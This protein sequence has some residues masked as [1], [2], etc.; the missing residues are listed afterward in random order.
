MNAD[1][2]I[3]EIER[4]SIDAGDG[5]KEAGCHAIDDCSARGRARARYLVAHRTQN[6][7]C[8]CAHQKMSI[9]ARNRH[10][11]S[12]QLRWQRTDYVGNVKSN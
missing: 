2:E 1:Q 6:E 7:T 12:E 3:R 5:E 10:T 11:P 4:G 9:A 8:F